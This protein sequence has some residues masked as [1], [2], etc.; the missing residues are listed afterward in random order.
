M[1]VAFTI[2]LVVMLVSAVFW[3]FISNAATAEEYGFN[4]CKNGNINTNDI[5]QTAIGTGSSY[6]VMEG[7]RNILLNSQNAT[8]KLPMASTTKVMTAYIACISGKLNEVVTI[9]KSV[10]GVEGSSIYLKEGEKYKLIDLVYGL[11]LRSGND[12]AE[13]IARYLGGSIEGFAKMMNEQ[14]KLMGLK[15]TNFVNPHGLHDDNHYTTAYDLAYITCEALKNEDFAKVCATK[16]YKFQ[17]AG[18]EHKCYINKNK[19]LNLYDDCIGVKTGYTKKAG[20]CLVSA[21]KRNGVTIVSVVLNQYDMWNLSMANLNK[22]FDATQGVL[23]GKGGQMFAK[24]KN[25]AG[26]ILNLGFKDDI[27][28]A[29][30]KN[31]KVNITYEINLN[32]NI[33]N[34]PEKGEIVGEIKFFNGKHLLFTEKIYTI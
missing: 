4:N 9:P 17:I 7:D 20:R 11:M 2:L 16:I 19:L 23:L 32:K 25:Q 28:F 30:L 1:I 21:A 14:V 27:Y 24:V 5:E 29:A 10:V 13:A 12:A 34:N 3:A 33:P 18:G 6:A 31:E 8:V 15:G 26:H 22:G